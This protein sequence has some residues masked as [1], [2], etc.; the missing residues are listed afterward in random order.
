MKRSAVVLY[1]FLESYKRVKVGGN[2]KIIGRYLPPNHILY[3]IIPVHSDFV[4][5]I[6]KNENKFTVRTIQECSID[7]VIISVYELQHILDYNQIEVISKRVLNWH[8]K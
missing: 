4:E 8:R 5:Y 2:I 1:D 3:G 6:I 7:D